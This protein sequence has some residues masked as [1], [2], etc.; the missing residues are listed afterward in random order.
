VHLHPFV[1]VIIVIVVMM[2]YYAFQRGRTS[3]Y[4]YHCSHCGTS[5]PFSTLAA[6]WAPHRFG[7]SKFG[8]CPSCEQW[9][10]L[11]QVPRA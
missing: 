8:R 10:W 3:Q 5:F 4:L 2:G 11:D 1:L 7:G 6:T 9:S